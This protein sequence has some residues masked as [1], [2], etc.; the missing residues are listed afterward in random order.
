MYRIG[1]REKK[2]GKHGCLS[3]H[4]NGTSDVTVIKEVFVL[5]RKL[6]NYYFRTKTVT[7]HVQSYISGE[8][9]LAQKLQVLLE[10]YGVQE[11]QT[12]TLEII[13]LLLEKSDTMLVNT[14]DKTDFKHHVNLQNLITTVLIDEEF[15]AKKADTEIVR[16]EDF[17]KKENALNGHYEDLGV[18]GIGGMGE[19]RRIRDRS[20]NR[21]L[22]MKI[23]HPTLLSKQSITS[24]FIEE[25]Q[26]GAQLQHPN[27]VPVHQMGRLVDGRLYFT[28]KEVKG[29][30]FGDAIAE[31]HAAV[32]NKRWQ[33]SKSGWSL[34]RLI[35]AFHD[36]CRAV[37]YAH[38]KGVLHR[39]L[40]PENIMLGEYGE[41]LVVDWGI[42]KVLG[43][44]DPVL[45]QEE[46]EIVSTERLQARSNVTRMG[47]VTG[48]PAYMSPE[49]ARGEINKLDGRTDIYALGSILYEIL[50]GSPAYEGTSALEVLQKVLAGPP[51]SIRPND[52]SVYSNS[53]IFFKN[54]E[55]IE[56]PEV[57][58]VE[59]PLPEELI[60]ICEKSMQ[61]NI[62]DRYSSAKE[63]ADA[64]S[65][66]L[67]GSKKREQALKVVEE[68]LE[69][70]Q[71]RELL[72]RKAKKLQEEAKEGLKN[73]PSWETET[74]KGQWWDKE[75]K[76]SELILQS[77]LLDIAQE[78]LLTAALTH[79]S[80][81]EEAHIAL[82]ERYRSAHEKAEIERD[83]SKIVQ[84]EVKLRDH[85]SSLPDRHPHQIKHFTYLKGIGAVS[86]TTKVDDVEVLLEEYVPHHRRLIP[87][88]VANLGKSPIVSHHLAMG[89]YRLRLRKQGYHEVLYPIHVGR[90][91]HWDG[92]D[93]F[94]VQRPILLPK[95]GTLEPE[96][97]Y[98][99]EG[100][101]WAG[102]ENQ[103]KQGL[104]RKRVW[105]DSFVMKKFPVT[106]RDYLAFLNDLVSTGMEE[107]ALQF[108]PRERSGQAGQMGAMIYGRRDNGL[109]V[110]VSD[111][112]GDMWELD[113]PVCMVDWHSSVAY[114]K[115]KAKKS[116]LAWR[117]PHEL[118]WEKGA[119]GVDGRLL[120]WGDDLDPS[121]ACIRHSHKE[122]VLP[123][124]I[125]SFPID[126]SVYGV[127]GLCGNM[128]DWT[129]SVWSETWSGISLKNDMLDFSE[130]STKDP[131]Y[132]VY[133]GGSWRS[134]DSLC[135]V[136][137]RNWSIESFRHANVGIRL[138]RCF[139]QENGDS[140]YPE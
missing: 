73:I 80:D 29:S 15:P 136:N 39:D 110:L 140:L 4:I 58:E 42:A 111:S 37:A 5:F 98:I 124:V 40:K 71:S 3:N 28:M 115:W 30:S 19:V 13:S 88:M 83:K 27:I 60:D 14:L 104:Q 74:I 138:A 82:A 134:Y 89:S 77:Q 46:E 125:D 102:G 76:A 112:D 6:S 63:M 128:M 129:A 120:V 135:H 130:T 91:E 94:G 75:K 17:T 95:M 106:N 66:W 20:L 8:S 34:R 109:F 114:A 9:M 72:E 45:D 131:S 133:R 70:T 47:A 126:E 36:V 100:W 64:I 24:R 78:H 1:T 56:H 99:P 85:A 87:K 96:D 79:K 7:L 53:G 86:L 118:E 62:E 51:P 43:H 44:R 55:T 69:L 12:I 41:V 107:K 105:V 123:V 25:A 32:E 101:F 18:L 61:R 33:T 108:V 81:L 49:Q 68:A 21:T 92:R 16:I 48:T 11:P 57:K 113:W 137:R 35:V 23:I 97:C 84:A 50:T 2:L 65:D 52:N 59:L 26:V 67:D 119:R 132:R 38:S 22:A 103:S 139:G 121:Y 117:L 93:P 90:G 116:Q 122:Q 54:F 31:V 127:R 10:K